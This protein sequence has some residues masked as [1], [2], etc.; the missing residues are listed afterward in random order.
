MK[1]TLLTILQIVVTV[2]LLCWIFRDPAKREQMA[3]A[4]RTA[5]FL[6]LI[7]GALPWASPFPSRPNAGAFFWPHRA[8]TW[9]GGA[10]CASS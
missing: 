7:P 2:L 6:W 4:L 5:N 3:T 8:S 9:D 10:R 1:R